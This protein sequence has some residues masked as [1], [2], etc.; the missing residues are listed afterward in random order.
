MMSLFAV[1][2]EL[3]VPVAI[4]VEVEEPEK[5]FVFD[6]STHARPGKP[7]IP[8][9]NRYCADVQ[10]MIRYCYEVRDYEGAFYFEEE[11]EYWMDNF[12][13]YLPVRSN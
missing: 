8:A 12:T 6:P 1:I 11:L 10:A 7:M 5:P 3:Q 2:P 13:V 9:L 4:P